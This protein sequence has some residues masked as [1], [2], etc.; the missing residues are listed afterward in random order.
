[1]P[2]PSK[3]HSVN[4]RRHSLR[5]V[6]GVPASAGMLEDGAYAW[7][8]RVAGLI[9]CHRSEAPRVGR[10]STTVSRRARSVRGPVWC[11]LVAV[12]GLVLVATLTSS[13]SGGR[14]ARAG[15]RGLAGLPVAAW[16][17]VSDTLGRDAAAYRVRSA[18]PVVS[19]RNPGQHL[20]VAFGRSGV[21]IAAGA[22][23]L[24]LRLHAYGYASAL[25]PVAGVS[26]RHEANRV[27]Y[28]HG[29]LTEWWV[30]GPLGL[31]QGFML[32]APPAGGHSGPLTLSLAV[33]GN[34]H[35][36]VSGRGD[37]ITFSGAGS[38]LAYRDLVATDARGRTLPAWL[39]LRGGELLLRISDTA[40][41]YPLRVDPFVQQA[42]LT[43]SDGA[44]GDGLGISVAV[45][46]TRSSSARHTPTARPM[47]Q[48]T[49]SSSPARAGL[50]RPRRRS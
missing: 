44:A 42:K 13:V 3:F 18:G 12:L 25:H 37:A 41:S 8:D 23:S 22:A 36:R 43:A 47:G 24:Q 20:G 50:M 30:N 26:P 45:S 39:E 16:G 28:V 31:E 5:P 10:T 19:A 21:A 15:P 7:M 14:H 4:T 27:V 1:M 11:V 17:P 29:G 40:A 2:P 35:A 6:Q 33:S 32:P 9:A 48:R 49:C 34:M 46:A 38:E